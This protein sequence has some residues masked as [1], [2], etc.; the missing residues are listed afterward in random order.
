MRPSESDIAI[1]L[2][3][4]GRLRQA[5]PLLEAAAA[6]DP[7]DALIVATLAHVLDR[8]DEPD[9]TFAVFAAL[10]VKH[11]QH[12]ALLR[13]YAAAAIATDRLLD[14][15]QALTQLIGRQPSDPWAEIELGRLDL[16]M[17]DPVSARSHVQAALAMDPGNA[18]ALWEL[19]QLDDWQL[20]PDRRERLEALCRRERDPQAL[21]GL[22]ATLTRVAERE[23]DF[24]AAARHAGIAN[25][26][27]AALPGPGGRYDPA[28][29]RRQIQTTIEQWTQARLASL[30]QSGAADPRPVFVIGLPRSGTTLL[31]RMLAAHP[32]IIGVGEQP[33]AIAS[34][35][36]ALLAT[37]SDAAMPSPAATG[38]AA[39]WH[40]QALEE[41]ARRL[42]LN[43]SAP[44]IVDK[45]PD[46]YLLVGWLHA[47]FP[48][49]AIVH[50]LRDPR[51]VAISCWTTQFAGVPWATSLDHI[52]GRIE[53]HRLLMG[54]WRRVLGGTFFELRHED[55]IAAPE[56]QL[57]RL[58][59]NLRLDWD[60]SVMDYAR[61]T[62]FVASASRQQ[63]R[64]PLHMRSVGRWRHYE[65]ALQPILPR[66][67]A[68]A[69]ADAQEALA[70]RP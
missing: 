9:H 28:A 59:T 8:L 31:E 69:L 4:E 45:M 7:D 3:R 18:A 25:T 29:H 39:R 53:Q 38:D 63:V 37:G 43:P 30:R 54:H 14:A 34:L 42:G 22:H 52:A 32:A 24:L 62:G 21:A 40:L 17:G 57:R 65:A 58:L 12:P 16:G 11:P 35:R 15:R 61:H 48:H 55:L 23:G 36:R 2:A 50:C 70:S 27:S 5:L 13:R 10:R 64:E 41:R 33:L 26:L 46:N 56:A 60:A 47:A 20:A 67:H 6:S 1:R 19:A 68:I 51:D 44:R 66:L 49:A